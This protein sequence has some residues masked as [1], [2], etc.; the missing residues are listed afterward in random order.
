MINLKLV[1][2]GALLSLLA[3]PG[4]ATVIDFTNT[5]CKSAG[6]PCVI[7]QTY[8]DTDDVDVSHRIIQKSNGH[9][10]GIGLFE[11]KTVGYGDLT[12][13]VYGG[14]DAYNYLSEITLTAKPGRL[15]SLQSFDF[16]TF[17][18]RAAKVPISVFDL[19]GNVLVSGN[20]STNS[21]KHATLAA[22]TGYLSGVI[23]RWG[24]DSVNVGLDNITY[25]AE[26][27]L[28]A[29]EPATW[30]M[31]LMGFGALGTAMRRRQ[32]SSFNLA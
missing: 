22:N 30:A 3:L 32:R 7:P 23:I 21:P 19:A 6:V 2:G 28:P 18:N 14:Y 11:Y 20:F 24:P 1:A 8:G 31:M 5:N 4:H 12:H 10:V 15:L 29:P 17:G 27:A 9:T 16:A 26:P 13:V 25:N